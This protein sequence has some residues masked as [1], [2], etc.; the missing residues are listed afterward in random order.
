MKKVL[1]IGG[2]VVVSLV[3]IMLVGALMMGIK[4]ISF[5]MHHP[6]FE[7]SGLALGG[8]DVVSYFKGTPDQGNETLSHEWNGSKWLF[9][10]PNNLE[11]F[12]N[13]PEKFVPQYGGYCAFAVSAGFTAPADPNIWHIENSKLYIFSNEDVKNEFKKNPQKMIEDCNKEWQ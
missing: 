6:V 5:G 3:M 9:S 2:F 4:P 8:K 10:S 7:S 11:Q 1:K 12:K 13:N